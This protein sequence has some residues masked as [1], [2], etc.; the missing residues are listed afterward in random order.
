M[1]SRIS[2]DFLASTAL[3]T[4]M[5][6]ALSALGT[7]LP[8]EGQTL[9]SYGMPGAIDTPTATAP[10]EGELMTTISDS[11]YGRRVTIGFQPFERLTGALR[12]SQIDGIDPERDQ[13]NDRSFDIQFQI[14]EEAGWRP[15]VAVGLRDFLGTGVYSG[16]YFVATKNFTPRLRASGGIGW[17]RLG[18]DWRRTD[19]TDEGGKPNVDDWFTGDARP[20][21]SIEWQATDKL[22][23][24]AEYSYD[25]Y[26]PEVEGGADEPNSKVNL[27]VNYR[28]DDTF[29]IGAYTIGGNVFGI[30]G[31]MSLNANKSPY[32]SGLEPAPAPVRPRPVPQADPEG[33]SGAWTA[34]ATAQPVIQKALKKALADDGQ[35]LESMSLSANRAEIRIRNKRYLSQ[36]EAIGHSARLMTRALPPSVETF[37]IT[38]VENGLPTSSVTLRRSDIEALENTA[39]AHI[40]QRATIEDAIPR[41]SELVTTPGVYPT[42]TWGLKPYLQ[43]G[44]FDPD[45]PYGYEVGAEVDGRYEIAPGL[46]LSGTVRQRAFGSLDQKGPA[47]LTPSEYLAQG[48][49]ENEFGIPRVRS[50]NRMYSGNSSPTIPDLTL[51][52]Y[53]KPVE[54]IYTRVT[55]GLLERAYGGASAEILWKPVDSRLAFGAEI[56]RVRKRDFRKAFEFRDYE[57]TTGHLSAYYDFGIGLWGQLDIGQYLAEDVGATLTLNR[58]FKNGWRVSA[59]ATKTDISEEEFGEGSFDKGVAISIP[60][61]WVAGTPTKRRAETDIRSLLRDGGAQ[62]DVQGR[63]YE[64]VRESQTGKLYDGWGRFW[65]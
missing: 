52:W 38:S 17:G 20:F 30:R 21:A 62:L 56:N 41:P 28:L 11:D 60:F 16:E 34:D 10:P 46:I 24:L 43:I 29:Q 23:L 1:H 5:V 53:A 3:L 54:N 48:T 47:D 58:E 33:W 37:V 13:L 25:D 35:V 64:T 55:V 19:Y 45:D 59:Y 6:S 51:A 7:A 50:D 57:V 22:S 8:V 18:G 61:S 12:Y 2:P 14:F 49:D 36:A 27:G 32:P 40:A 63:L 26:Q 42:F 31:S 4:I 9:N 39:S 44:V 15:S 65:R